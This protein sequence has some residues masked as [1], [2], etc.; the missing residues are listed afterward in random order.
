MC[1]P[2]R[3]YT[4]RSNRDAFY[5]QSGLPFILEDGLYLP[6]TMALEEQYTGLMHRNSQVLAEVGQVVVIRMEVKNHIPLRD[7]LMFI[8]RSVAGI[9]FESV[10]S[11]S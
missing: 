2:Q 5:D 6:M 9:S 7:T 3:L 1:V 4:T 8:G 10:S 11:E